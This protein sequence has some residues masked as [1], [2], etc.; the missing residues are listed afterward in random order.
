MTDQADSLA[1]SVYSLRRL[2]LYV[3]AGVV[4]VVFAF[5]VYWLIISSLKEPSAIRSWPPSLFTL[6]L[7]LENFR[8]LVSDTNFPRWFKNSVLITAGNIVFTITLSTTAGYA[9]TRYDIPQKKNL[10]RLLL[11]T[12]MFPP[13]LLGIP[14]FLLFDAIGLQNTLLGIMLAHASLSLPFGTWIMWQF[15]QTVP[16]SWEESS[17]VCGASRL[18]SM[19]EIAL[20]GA[21]PGIVAV[22]IFTFSVSWNDFTLA[23]ML[24][25]DPSVRV[26]TVGI[27]DFMT[28][29]RVLWGDLTSAGVLL[30]LPPMLLIFFLNK[31]I[32]EGFSMGGF[33]R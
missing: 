1:P 24:T 22:A 15:F 29:G 6:D 19:V 18:R 8:L 33:D 23:F 25:T 7:T 20:P 9:L 16:I 17:W 5:P 10:A 32:L 12:Y 30:I 14:Y 4:T 3:L 28:G 31:Y 26:L 11:L 27:R 13:I 2:T 21:F